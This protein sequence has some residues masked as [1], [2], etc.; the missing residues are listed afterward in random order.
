M[1]AILNA[2]GLGLSAVCSDHDSGIASAAT[3]LKLAANWCGGC[4]LTQVQR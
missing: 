4:F 1:Q 3:W 2:T